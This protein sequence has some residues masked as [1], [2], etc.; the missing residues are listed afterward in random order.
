MEIPKIVDGNGFSQ[1]FSMQKE[2]LKSY[3]AIEGL[4]EY[5]IDINSK[6][7]QKLLKGF[8]QRYTEELSEAFDELEMAFEAMS[9]N[10]Q[11]GAQ[12]NIRNYNTE[13]ADS[14]HFLLEILIYTGMEEE[15]IMEKLCN[16][17]NEHGY[18]NIIQEGDCLRTLIDTGVFLNNL[19]GYNKKGV[20]S[21]AF[22]VFNQMETI[23]DPSIMGG[24]YINQ[25]IILLHSTYL[26]QIT[27]KINKTVNELKNKDWSQT[28][29]LVNTT[30]FYEKLLDTLI[31]ISQYLDIANINILGVFNSY[32]LK[33]QVNLERIKNKY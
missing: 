12:E 28:E 13:I 2:I 14:M 15:M 23:H 32:Y 25:E 27:H 8:V 10:N 24:A 19:A 3:I 21:Q 26:W 18:G 17:L 20:N 31:V 11:K 6:S 7:G 22:R 30:S 16:Q 9:E 33:N 4:P 5:P 29:K 1:M